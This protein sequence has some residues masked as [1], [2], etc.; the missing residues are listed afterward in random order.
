MTHQTVFPLGETIVTWTATDV[1]ENTISNTQIITVVDTTAPEIIGPSDLQIEANHFENNTG[2]L[3]GPHS[4]DQVEISTITNDAPTVFPLGETIVTWTA[5]DSSG[6][7]ASATQIITVV[8]TT[9]PLSQFHL[10][11]KLKYLPKLE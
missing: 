1:Y 5:T 10:I 2:D 9:S 4:S 3:T 11:L 6:N 8:D 7:S